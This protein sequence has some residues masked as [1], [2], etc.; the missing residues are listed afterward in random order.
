MIKGLARHEQ[1]CK[2]EDRGGQMKNND[3]LGLTLTRTIKEK[4]KKKN[5][6]VT[7][8]WAIA[9]AA[10]KFGVDPDD[11]ILERDN[12]LIRVRVNV[13]DEDD[14]EFMSLEQFTFEV[15][16]FPDENDKHYDTFKQFGYRNWLVKTYP[17][18][19]GKG[20]Y[21]KLLANLKM[22]YNW[23]R[24]EEYLD[25]EL[26]PPYDVLSE[27]LSGNRILYQVES[28]ACEL[29]INFPE[30]TCGIEV[31]EEDTGILVLFIDEEGELY[32]M[33]VKPEWVISEEDEVFEGFE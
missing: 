33:M 4:G 1:V 15:Y 18:E 31:W 20:E 28:K 27:F 29:T 30:F 22:D 32:P 8:K 13:E 17:D 14:I 26:E 2:K 10:K 3:W 16:G 21:N 7:D 24:L 6:P 9:Y 19:W 5:I 11:I 23:Y 12:T 25:V